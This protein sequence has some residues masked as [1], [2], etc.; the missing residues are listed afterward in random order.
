[1]AQYQLI[2]P[3]I[4][5]TKMDNFKSL[6]VGAH[7]WI[8]IEEC[9]E[10]VSV[11]FALKLLMQMSFFVSQ[12]GKLMFC[13]FVPFYLLPSKHFEHPKN[14][15]QWLRDHRDE[16]FLIVGLEQTSSSHSLLEFQFSNRPTVFLLGKEKEGIPVELLQVVDESVEIPQLGIIRR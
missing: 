16:G 10:E 6:T 3:D 9:K 2:V 11:F 15:L 12:I 1:M 14:L 13:P 7:E 8:D 5:L 4:R